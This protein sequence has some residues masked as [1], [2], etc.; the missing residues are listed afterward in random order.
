MPTALAGNSL[1]N[2][3]IIHLSV[4]TLPVRGYHIDTQIQHLSVSH[5][6]GEYFDAVIGFL[7][8]PPGFI[9]ILPEN[10]V[11]VK[12]HLTGARQLVVTLNEEELYLFDYVGVSSQSQD[13]KRARKEL[14]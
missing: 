14:G 12:V 4:D 3:G 7:P 8:R 2:P 5:D 13:G 9:E 1:Q 11:N 6:I 10:M